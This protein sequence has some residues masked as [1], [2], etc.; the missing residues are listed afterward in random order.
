MKKILILA[1]IWILTSLHSA[2]PQAYLDANVAAEAHAANPTGW[3]V[4][5]LKTIVSKG[6]DSNTW[7]SDGSKVL[8]RAFT[9]A[10]YY[11]LTT[12]LNQNLWPALWTTTGNELR[13]WYQTNNVTASDVSLR[14]AQL[15]GLPTSSLNQYNAIVE[16]WVSPSNI[17]RPTKDPAI[18]A[19]PTAL[20]TE[21]FVKP[22]GMS[23]ADFAKFKTWYNNNIVSSYGDPDPNK[24]YPWTQFGYT[25]D[26]GSNGTSLADIQG[27]SEFVILGTKAGFTAP[28]TTYS[29]YSIQSYLYQTGGLSTGNFNVTGPCDTIWAGTNFQNYGNNITITSTGSVSGGQGIY[30]SSAGY[31]I[32]NSGTI[33]GPTSQK[34][35][36]AAPAGYGIYFGNGGT[37]VNN[38]TGRIYGDSNGIGSAAGDVTINNYGYISGTSY[39]VK[40]GTGNDSINVYNNGL[41][42][43]NI[44]LGTGTNSITINNGGTV[45]GTVYSSGGTDTLTVNRGGSLKGNVNYGLASGKVVFNGG[46]YTSVINTAAKTSNTITAEEIDLNSGS[47]LNVQLSGNNMLKDG[48]SIQVLHCE[49]LMGDF[50]YV[51]SPYPMLDFGQ[52]RSSG[53]VVLNLRVNHNSYGDVAGLLDSRLRSTGYALDE[54]A[55]DAAG[56]MENI[57]AQIDLMTSVG[58][59]ASAVRQLAPVPYTAIP[60]TTFE[61]DRAFYD[62]VM[63]RT[64]FLN[65]QP[66]TEA[67]S[68]LTLAP[69]TSKESIAE[70]PLAPVERC[71]WNPYVTGTGLW[72]RQNTKGNVPGYTYD[73]GGGLVGM[74]RKFGENLTTGLAIGGSKTVVNMR[75]EGG[76]RINIDGARP[77]LYGGYNLKN[78]EA[79]LSLGYGYNQYDTKREIE[80]ASID[81]TA[82]G[83]HD[84]HE[85]SSAG[86][87][88]WKFYLT[89]KTVL[90]PLAGFYYSSLYENAFDEE[91]AGAANLSIR[92]RTS[93]S[94]KSTPGVRFYHDFTMLETMSLRP[95]FTARWLHEFL[96]S[97]YNSTASFAN[98]NSFTYNGTD[99]DRDAA[100]LNMKLA[101]KPFLHFGMFAEYSTIIAPS[102][103]SNAVYAGIEAFF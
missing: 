2:E 44:D 15:H 41:L 37:V 63:N 99:L 82:K 85:F 50:T 67:A 29:V 62:I 94:L 1:A 60:H 48:Q 87:L 91:D 23:D 17:F 75:D 22:A 32:N 95:E 68:E 88:G 72:G 26:W 70:S 83:S 36:G 13:D 47:T 45:S 42:E 18:N 57:L 56:D 35:Y 89:E 74:E 103:Y 84:G 27:L 73:M 46:S 24:R 38:S 10:Q 52:F 14:T 92:S 16:I 64:R 58:D 81:R 4:S 76:S 39:A 12:K 78:F 69:K 54:Q 90:E 43:G 21:A 7:N 6:A 19:Q 31:T 59:I 34:Y 71:E 102:L 3:N 51:N 49:R 80:F 33:Y 53:S 40:T 86:D 5:N 61:T 98:G 77:I 30:V 66:E 100:Q 97:S 65:E 8:M 96:D 20:P 101:F 79:G 93:N 9:N 11:N 28:I 25:Y 55:P